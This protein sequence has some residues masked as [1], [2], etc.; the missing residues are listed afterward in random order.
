MA[1][2]AD[3]V[4]KL[5]QMTGAGIMDCKNA[6]KETDGDVE[7]AVELLRKKGIAKADKKAGR[8]TKEGLIDAY[9]HPGSK[10]GVLVE[11][12]CET[13][14]VAKTDDFKTF[15]RDIAMQIAAAN[16]MVVKREELPQ[17]VIDRE[18][19]IYK[20]QAE[21]EKKPAH[22][23]EKIATGRM[24]KFYQEVVL[25]EQSFVKDSDKT[26]EQLLKETIG[27]IGEN[28]SIRRF[29]RFQLGE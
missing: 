10:L 16:P 25:L 22:I 26:I 19:A 17:D 3:D 20:T 14:F 6:L 24:E 12:N 7:K 9:I 27:K 13:D 28:I 4:K 15:V 8:E 1:V 2:T 21:N 29:S 18:M 23:A 5:R 11:I